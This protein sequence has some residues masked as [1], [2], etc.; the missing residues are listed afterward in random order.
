MRS[1]YR[2]PVDLRP[3]LAAEIL[4]I[5]DIQDI[6]EVGCLGEHLTCLCA[7][8]RR[9]V[10]GVSSSLNRHGGERVTDPIEDA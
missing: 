1:M 10:W 4:E 5:R 8:T 2:S 7:Q 9:I 6:A 3:V